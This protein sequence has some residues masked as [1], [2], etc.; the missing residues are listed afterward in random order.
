MIDV[1]RDK[2]K[3][4]IFPLLENRAQDAIRIC[5]QIK[6]NTNIDISLTAG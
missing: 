5:K 4:G 3:G 2:Q 1:I 6:D